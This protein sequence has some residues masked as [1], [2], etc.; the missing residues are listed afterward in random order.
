MK[1]SIIFAIGSAALALA[2]PVSVEIAE[3]STTV[4]TGGTGIGFEG[5]GSGGDVA[6]GGNGGNTRKGNGGNGGAGGCVSP[7]L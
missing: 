2:A 7:L 4:V 6:D 5:K 3:R 1:Y